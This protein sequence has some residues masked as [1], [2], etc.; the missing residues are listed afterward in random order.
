LKIL[1]GGAL[2]D[3]RAVSRFFLE[4]RTMAFLEHPNIVT[5][6]EVGEYCLFRYVVLAFIDGD[7]LAKRLT[8]FVGRAEASASLLAKV[9]RAVH[10]MHGRGVLHCDLE[11]SN[12]LIDSRGEPYVTD[13]GQARSADPELS[14][15]GAILGTPGYIAPE[16]H[17]GDNKALTAAIDVYGLGATLHAMI[18]GREELQSESANEPLQQVP[19]KNREQPS[20]PVMNV[21]R[22]L[23]TICLKCLEREPRRRY[24]TALALAEDL[25]RW[26]ARN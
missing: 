24:A 5:I 20:G 17:S 18:L 11:P 9:A 4:A 1:R 13:F 6:R 7:S 10:Y 25:E 15:V 12:I 3:D 22:R 16:L 19:G 8:D 14:Q 21:D 23:R 2:A 26:L